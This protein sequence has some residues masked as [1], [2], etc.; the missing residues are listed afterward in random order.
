MSHLGEGSAWGECVVA[1][2]YDEIGKIGT[3]VIDNE[4]EMFEHVREIPSDTYHFTIF[5]KCSNW[6]KNKRDRLM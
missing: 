3:C 6:L 4:H 5:N 2:N 1:E